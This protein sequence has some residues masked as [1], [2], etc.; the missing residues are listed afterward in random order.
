MKQ[1]DINENAKIYLNYNDPF[2]PETVRIFRPV[3][4]KEGDSYCVLLGPDP[5]EGIFGCGNSAE[6]A[7]I[8]WEHHLFDELNNHGGESETIQ[9]V[10]R[11]LKG[12]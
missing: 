10:K 5:Q 6:K 8:D 3:V 1:M 2:L 9:F 7:V 12:L 4:F 11:K